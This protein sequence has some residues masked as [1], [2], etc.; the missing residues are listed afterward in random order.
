M[1]LFLFFI[2]FFDVFLT[3]NICPRIEKLEKCFKNV[4][5]IKPDD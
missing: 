1:K 3:D 5:L 4:D 2:T